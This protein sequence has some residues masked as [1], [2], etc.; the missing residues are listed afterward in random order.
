MRVNFDIPQ[1]RPD[2]GN[3]EG[4]RLEI[5][6]TLI[7]VFSWSEPEGGAIRLWQT[8]ALAVFY[9]DQVL[10]RKTSICTSFGYPQPAT[11]DG[12]QLWG[13]SLPKA[14]QLTLSSAD[15]LADFTGTGTVPVSA[16]YFNLANI[17]ASGNPGTWSLDNQASVTL[18][19]HY[20]FVAVP[21]P[22]LAA[23]VIAGGLSV[24]CRIR[25]GRKEPADTGTA[26]CADLPYL[27]RQGCGR[28][29]DLLRI[30]FR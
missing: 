12:Q 30:Q 6:G 10:A 11:G 5:T 9:G 4:V 2:L 25:K 23:L 24:V 17:S 20:D 1:F 28:K 27:G 14:G 8:N 16:E 22:H 19:L 3:L 18:E 13:S 26:T 15:E 7:S 29:S 21:E